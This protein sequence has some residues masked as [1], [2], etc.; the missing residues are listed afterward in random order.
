MISLKSKN[1]TSNCVL[2]FIILQLLF[3]VNVPD[4]SANPASRILHTLDQPDGFAFQ[5]RQWGDEFYHG[6]ET[7]DGYTIA[8]DK[9]L[10]SWAYAVNDSGGNL[11]VS[12]FVVGKTSPPEGM[13][14]HLR[15]TGDAL[16]RLKKVRVDYGRA[17]LS[18]VSPL[19]IEPMTPRTGTN[20]ILVLLVNFTDTTPLFKKEDYEDVYFKK[21][22]RSLADY[23]SE[24]SYG[25]LT[26]TSGPGGIQDWWTAPN[27]HN[28]YGAD[29]PDDPF[30]NDVK[31]PEAPLA[32][33]KVLDSKDFN[34]APYDQDGDCYVDTVA[35][36]FQGKPQS[37]TK[38]ADDIWPRQSEIKPEYVTKTPCPK[39]GKIIVKKYTVQTEQ[40]ADGKIATIGTFA[41]EYGH[42]L[43]L[44]D[45]YDTTEKSVGA[46]VWTV[47]GNG[48][49]NRRSKEGR[50]GDSPAHF[51]AWSKF[52]LGW[53]TP[54]KVTSPLI[55]E[56]IPPVEDTPKVYQFLT[57]TK[58][59]GEYFL[60]EN[61]QWK[62][63]D[64][65]IPGRGLL[66]WHIDGNL[67]NNTWEADQ[68][69]VNNYACNNGIP[70]STRHFGVALQQADGKWHMEKKT[71]DWN[72]GDEGD[73]YPGST[74]NTS[75]T[76]TS[77]PNSKLYNGT[78]SGISITD[79]SM[80][81][82]EWNVTATLAIVF[83]GAHG[84][85]S[86]TAI[87]FADK[88]ITD[89]GSYE[90]KTLTLTSDGSVDFSVGT[91]TVSDPTNFTIT[92]DTCS[93]LSLPAK[94]TCQI[95]VQFSPKTAGIKSANLVI[96]SN[97]G[98]TDATMNQTTN[99]SIIGRATQSD[100]AVTP[101]SL[102]FGNV[103]LPDK[104][105]AFFTGGCSAVAN[106]TTVEVRCPVNI[107]NTSENTLT[108]ITAAVAGDRFTI[109][110]QGNYVNT[111]TLS[112]LAPSATQSVSVVYTGASDKTVHTGTLSVATAGLRGE[113]SLTGQ[114]NTRPGKPTNSSPRKGAIDI[115]MMP[116]FGAS[117]FSDVDYDNAGASIWEISSDNTFDWDSIVFR[118][119][120][121]ADDPTSLSIPPGIL[122][123]KTTYYWR[124]TYIDNRGLASEP[125]EGTPFTTVA[126]K[127][128]NNGT[129]TAVT[130]VTDN[131]GIEITAISPSVFPPSIA[132]I[133]PR[134]L[135]DF[136]ATNAGITTDTT[137]PSVAIVR[138]KGGID[139]DVIGMATPVGTVIDQ[140]ITTVNTDPAFAAHSVPAGYNFPYGVV[141][142]RV[143]D[144][145]PDS[146][147]D[148]TFYTPNDLPDGTIWYKYDVARGWLKVDSTGTY[149]ASGTLLSTDMKFTI[150]NGK[151][152]LTIK[153]DSTGDTSSEIIAGKAVI[154][155][156]GMFG[157]SSGLSPGS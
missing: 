124:V 59:S 43:G 109:L 14:K 144:V 51:D 67:I 5:A 11:V 85:V 133:S 37:S 103:I 53:V 49:S 134:L 148:I 116:S 40:E 94:T 152:I 147:I 38:V 131:Q 25:K 118:A 96:P 126:A 69:T 127:M 150:T 9:L 93:G 22:S 44:P 114:S 123:P 58:N 89:T 1:I 115:S 105:A 138:A 80:P 101:A 143:T 157:I 55:N 15:L 140:V 90:T 70:C 6:W 64:Y 99:I 77:N 155:D 102:N 111:V 16:L 78:Q 27:T 74:T 83:S 47:M 119:I 28:Y 3:L 8:F 41:H 108:N 65:G 60:V 4:I 2:F 17:P 30:H 12:P 63:F 121:N 95:T 91:I 13:E 20:Y 88:A 66:V 84:T 139:K 154:A 129:T 39:G 52:Y 36:V 117:D 81:A 149:T 106:E 122:K 98:N 120:N 76:D 79:I 54:V 97:T 92:A 128:N 125:S 87:A 100:L 24:V 132:A 145:S 82:D 156:P 135:A 48:E 26:V 137:K 35:F 153:D 31:L 19:S 73:P 113:V 46:G 75:F 45:L 68:N 42:A 34:F 86:D 72:Y 57:G 112:S 7:E 18:M 141:S 23:F 29:D 71:G 107:K 104:T 136:T 33:I 62:G 130:T 151:G 21:G 61:R 56:S 32:A 142:F 50:E 10:Q 110:N 146:S